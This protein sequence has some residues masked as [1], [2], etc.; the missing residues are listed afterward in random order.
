VFYEPSSNSILTVE[1]G[2]KL[3]LLKYENIFLSTFERNP[4]RDPSHIHE[5]EITDHK[6][7]NLFPSILPPPPGEV[8][9]PTCLE[10]SPKRKRHGYR[11]CWSQKNYEWYPYLP[12]VVNFR[13]PIFRGMSSNPVI[14]HDGSGYSLKKEEIS[15]WQNVEFVMLT[16]AKA[17]GS[18]SL[19]PLEQQ[20]P[21]PP[22]EYGYTRSHSQEKFARKS[23]TKSLNAFQRLLG[24]C[25][26]VAA[27]SPSWKPIGDYRRFYSDIWVSELYDRLD[28]KSPDLHILAKLLLSSLWK[29]RGNHTGVVVGYNEGYDY[30]AVSRMVE[31]NVPVYVA[32]P[33]RGV[34]PYLRFPQNKYLDEF[35]PKVEHFEDLEIPRSPEPATAPLPM[36]PAAYHN[37]PPTLTNRVTYDNPLDY[38]TRRL[39]LIPAELDSSPRRQAML[40][41]LASALKHNNIGTA[42]FYEFECVVVTDRQTGRAKVGWVRN[43]LGKKLGKEIFEDVDN[44]HLW[45]VCF[46]GHVSLL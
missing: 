19:T 39:A 24:F 6:D 44:R 16:V 38:V 2:T 22:S 45:H 28:P 27:E 15:M 29:M 31:Y 13:Y 25:A 23:A 33:S 11:I 8:H 43:Q 32:W 46:F 26:Y 7:N 20:D 18:R 21:H 17:L 9:L 35:R 40:D 41:R 5:V 12:A 36:T 30:P 4:A 10:A 34:D 42:R 14:I 3:R 37:P 1:R